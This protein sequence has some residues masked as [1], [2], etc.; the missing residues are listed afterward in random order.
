[1]RG[2]QLGYLP[3]ERAPWIGGM[4]K[5]GRE[6]RAVF[7]GETHPGGWIRLAFDGA[8]PTLPAPK[9]KPVIEIDPDSDDGFYPD[10]TYPD[11]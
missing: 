1:M 8:D 5:Q 7:Q 3:A 6:V 9:T 4:I 2:V 10:E 11:E